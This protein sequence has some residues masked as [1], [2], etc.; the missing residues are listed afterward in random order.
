MNS[1]SNQIS[2]GGG[3]LDPRMLAL[4]FASVATSPQRVGVIGGG[5][6]GLSC[7]RRLQ[8]LGVEAV[9]FDTGK[10]APGGR[11][12][13]RIFSGAPADHA[14][15]Y[16]STPRDEPSAFGLFAE[17]MVRAGALRL[18]SDGRVGTLAPGG[19]FTPAPSD[20]VRRYIGSDGIGSLAAAMAE[21]L[22][23]RQDV[24][25]PPSGGLRYDR[26]GGCIVRTGRD[27]PEERFDAVVVSHNG[28]CAERLTSS[29]PAAEVHALLRAKFGASVGRPREGDAKMTLCS[30]YSL[31]F[32]VDAG[33]MPDTFDAAHVV[34]GPSGDGRSAA[35]ELQMLCNN[36]RKYPRA[37]GAPR[38]K[39]VWTALSSAR[40]GAAHKFPQ[41]ALEGTETE[42]E[43]RRLLLSAVERACGLPAGSVSN[44]VRASKLQLWGAATPLNRWDRDY[45]WDAPRGIGVCGDWLSSVASRAATVET[46]WTSGYLL[47]EHMGSRPAESL[48]IELGRGGGRFWAAN[49][50]LAGDAGMA[51]GAG[52]AEPELGQWVVDLGGGAV[53]RGGGAR[54]ATA[55]RGGRGTPVPPEGGRGGGDRRRADGRPSVPGT[56]RDLFLKNLPYA[57]GER[58]VAAFLSVAGAVGRVELVRDATGQSRGLARVRME[59][60]DGAASAVETL[61][62]ACLQGRSVSLALDSRPNK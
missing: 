18:W 19:A 62:G 35:P 54:G 12:S 20:S 50:G 26:K 29:T 1:I 27:N 9:V 33:V 23:V 40:F 11:S 46:A 53:A 3:A 56:G 21:G 24:W 37:D 30:I 60:S 7:A 51:Q 57:A 8:A 14:A 48:G 15:Q 28:K 39:H 32:E 52:H 25:V 10:H 45:L 5:I 59:T 44:S 38:Q 41:E 6:A 34:P 4:L 2:E 22:D 31:L 49:E 42:A 16:I 55:G 36:A 43:V 47:A 61:G 58:D 13:S 17:E